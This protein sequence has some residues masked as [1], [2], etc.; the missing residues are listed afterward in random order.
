MAVKRGRESV[1]VRVGCKETSSKEKVSFITQQD[2]HVTI[3]ENS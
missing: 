2:G 3:T 1:A